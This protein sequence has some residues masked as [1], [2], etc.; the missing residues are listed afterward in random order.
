MMLSQGLKGTWSVILIRD[1]TVGSLLLPLS[2][3]PQFLCLDQA[4]NL[5]HKGQGTWGFVQ[6]RVTGARKTQSPL[7]LRS[8]SALS[9]RPL[10]LRECLEILRRAWI[11]QKARQD[12]ANCTGSQKEDEPRRL[13]H[14][15]SCLF[16][17]YD[18]T[19]S[20]VQKQ[21]KCYVWPFWIILL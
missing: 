2:A 18:H 3:V 9:R 21:H 11:A 8:P 4:Q 20:T 6:Q 14:L 17:N 7:G 19:M 5:R 12:S 16:Y 15:E 1:R 10:A 13:D